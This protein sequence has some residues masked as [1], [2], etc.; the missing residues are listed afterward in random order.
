VTLPCSWDP[1][2]LRPVYADLDEVR[3]RISDINAALSTIAVGRPEWEP[4][5]FAMRDE[6]I[7]LHFALGDWFAAVWA[8]VLA[9]GRASTTRSRKHRF[10]TDLRDADAH[11]FQQ[12]YARATML[13]ID[14]VQ[15]ADKQPRAVRAMT[16]LRAGR[17]EY[18]QGMWSDARESFAYALGFGLKAR[19]D[20]RFFAEAEFALRCAEARLRSAAA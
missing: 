9:S 6:L 7:D 20:E 5:E 17:C 19:L 18:V 11:L 14:L 13:F 16:F 8:G 15:S 4:V 2:T 3:S 12:H 10:L 1:V